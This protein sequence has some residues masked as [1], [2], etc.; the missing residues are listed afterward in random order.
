[1]RF[2]PHVLNVVERNMLWPQ[3]R[4][5]MVLQ[6][7]VRARSQQHSSPRGYRILKSTNE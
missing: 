5:V 3:T 6:R 1:M 2:W 7:H 4:R